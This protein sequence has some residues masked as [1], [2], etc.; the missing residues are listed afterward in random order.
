MKE[1][2]N[3]RLIFGSIIVGFIIVAGLT[4]IFWTPYKIDDTSGLRL[5]PSSL[6]HLLG[7]DKLGRDLLSRTMSGAL[8]AVEVGFFAVLIGLVLGLTIGILA[9]YA[10]KKS[11]DAISSTLDI[12][13][14]FPTLLLAMLVVTARGQSL[15]SAIISIGIG[16]SIIVARL[17]RQLTKK[18]LATDFALAAKL[19]GTSRIRVVFLHILPN[20]W[21]TILVAVALQFGLA[22]LAEASLSYLGLGAP[23]PS[24][25]WGSLLQEAQSTIY[26]SP[27][28]AIAPG[29]SLVVL[30]IGVNLLADGLRIRFDPQS[31]QR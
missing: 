6:S 4:S 3:K 15:A 8:V 16:I 30:V 5:E 20:I 24:A 18:I 27:I 13:I 26:T 17:T 22:G 21:H 31:R 14:A 10:Q 19:S 2:L 11:D 12:L 23:P 28:S 9:G 1:N 29:L 25:S 7:T